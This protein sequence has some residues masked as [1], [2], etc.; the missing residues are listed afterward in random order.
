MIMAMFMM[1]SVKML[2]Q[3]DNREQWRVKRAKEYYTKQGHEVEI[4]ELEIGD[5]LFDN[6]VV[7]EMKMIPDFVSSIQNG[8]I[9][10]QAINQAENYDYHF[11]TVFGDLH[12]RSKAIAMS[13]NYREVNLYQ[14]ISAICS[15][16]RYT[17]VLQVFSP[18]VEEAFYTMEMQAKKCLQNKPIVKRFPRKDK[19]VCFNFLCHDIYGINSKKAQV[20]VDTYHLESL[21]DLFTL[22][23]QEL[24][25]IE[26]IGEKTAENIIGAIHGSED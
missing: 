23:K 3:I 22:T 13:R 12:T 1:R 5:Y 2:V 26:G 19:N 14:Y 6:K 21:N 25:Q 4:T 17:T 18:Y 16:N 24:L 7:F 8:K 20:I 15:L 9:F 10:N 11:V